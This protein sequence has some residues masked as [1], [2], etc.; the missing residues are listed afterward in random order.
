MFKKDT[1]DILSSSPAALKKINQISD[2]QFTW[3]A[4]QARAL[5]QDWKECEK[6]VLVKDWFGSLSSFG[7]R[8]NRASVDPKQVVY[9]LHKSQAPPKVLHTFLQLVED[10]QERE[11][12]AKRYNVASAVVDCLVLKRDRQAL[13]LYIDRHLTE[14]TEDWFYAQKEL[15]VQNTRWKN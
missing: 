14:N 1:D 9:I 2:S 10:L 12:C 3:V 7:T 15:S 11:D 13:L 5:R 8:K 4:L 6:L